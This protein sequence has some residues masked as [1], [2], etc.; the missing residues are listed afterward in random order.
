MRAMDKQS[1]QH[2]LAAKDFLRVFERRKVEIPYRGETIAYVA[3]FGM[4][5]GG[6]VSA[7]P[8]LAG[9][10]DHA[11]ELAADVVRSS[12]ACRGINSSSHRSL[13][14]FSGRTKQRNILRRSKWRVW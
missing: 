12:S 8:G 6:N 13:S 4:S 10:A 5:F 14:K 7:P 1:E 11:V 3:H 9:V 2:E